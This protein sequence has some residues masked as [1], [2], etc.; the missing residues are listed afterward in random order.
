MVVRFVFFCSHMSQFDADNYVEAN[1]LVT[2]PHIVPEWYYLPFYAILRAIP[3]KLG[4]VVAMV[5]AIVVLFFVPWL[6]TSRVRSAKYRP[7]YKW[8][9][10]LLVVSGLGLGYLGAKPPDGAYVFWARVFTFYYFA[11][12]LSQLRGGRGELSATI[13]LLLATVASWS[14]VYLAHDS[15][16]AMFNARAER[17]TLDRARLLLGEL[18]KERH[19]VELRVPG[20]ADLGWLFV[21]AN[22]LR[23]VGELVQAEIPRAALRPV[24]KRSATLGGLLS[25]FVTVKLSERG[26]LRILPR[27]NIRHLSDARKLAPALAERLVRWLDAPPAV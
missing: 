19:F 1:P 6:D 15:V 16:G 4:G 21:E 26:W 8:F 2:P 13:P 17:I 7:L 22:R 18:P 25:A 14:V 24:V 11:S 12:L 20:A 5:S 3:S 9:F 23:F 10:W 27:E